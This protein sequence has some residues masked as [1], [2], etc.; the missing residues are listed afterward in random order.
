MANADNFNLAQV[1]SCWR[2][3]LATTGVFTL[4]DIAELEDHLLLC[5]E[6]D[7][8]PDREQAF[9]QSLHRLGAP[10]SL[11]EQ[12]LV[13][14][15]PHWQRELFHFANLGIIIQVLVMIPLGMILFMLFALTAQ[16]F[17]LSERL[18]AALL[19]IPLALISLL[20]L[21]N[22]LLFMT[23]HRRWLTF[24]GYLLPQRHPAWLW[25]FKGLVLVVLSSLILM[26]GDEAQWFQ[27]P[28]TH[29]P[30][31]EKMQTI[32]LRS[33]TYSWMAMVIGGIGMMGWGWWK[34]KLKLLVLG[35]RLSS[36]FGIPILWVFAAN[37]PVLSIVAGIVLWGSVF[38]QYR[39][40]RALQT[41]QFIP[42]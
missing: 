33:L 30:G 17:S 11:R 20:Q 8:N 29:Y 21:G 6:S 41:E 15:R 35:R 12:Y 24:W 32:F 36:S 10:D 25:P 4:A 27:I 16:W 40:L 19:W 38:L 26:I 34:K 14:H 2:N 42:V 39:T 37:H 13:H 7:P 18:L 22:L 1:L 31:F 23:R 9:Q 5:Y 3:D 28:L